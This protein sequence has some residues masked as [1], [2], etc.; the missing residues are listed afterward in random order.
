[1]NRPK[2]SQFNNEKETTEN[3]NT[4][5]E[6]EGIKLPEISAKASGASPAPGRPAAFFKGNRGTQD[7]SSGALVK[8]LPKEAESPTNPKKAKAGLL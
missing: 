6:N 5:I 3:I 8:D 4:K 2:Q 1:M 7:F